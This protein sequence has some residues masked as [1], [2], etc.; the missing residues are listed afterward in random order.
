MIVRFD[1]SP[2]YGQMVPE[3]RRALYDIAIQFK[4][5]SILEIGTWKG[6]GSTYILASAAKVNCGKLYTIENDKKFFDI[7]QDIYNTDLMYLK[8]SVEF[9]FGDST[10]KI[11]ELI[12]TI[13]F[14][15]I[16]LDG[17]EDGQRTFNDFKLVEK[18]NTLKIIACHDWFTDKQSILKPHL[19]NNYEQI[20]CI[21]DTPTGFAAFKVSDK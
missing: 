1:A 21:D 15:M 2:N 11:K 8:P 4:C 9:I 16:F 14:D 7:A 10:E 19:N 5:R 18:E 6:V 17:A 13:E 3:E 20:C 12:D